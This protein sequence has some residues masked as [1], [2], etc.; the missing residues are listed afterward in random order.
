MLKLSAM[1]VE[2]GH[3]KPPV[4]ISAD[5]LAQ[6]NFYSRV[7]TSR[8]APVAVSIELTEG[9]DAAL[10]PSIYVSRPER[11]S[12]SVFYIDTA[13]MRGFHFLTHQDNGEV[14]ERLTPITELRK[15]APPTIQKYSV[16]QKV[17]NHSSNLSHLVEYGIEI[18]S[19][20]EQAIVAVT[21]HK[22]PDP[23]QEAV[24]LALLQRKFSEEE[25]AYT[26]LGRLVRNGESWFLG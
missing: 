12:S 4:E 2:L 20:N 18:P 8:P 1:I 7:L 24:E 3:F 11:G 23:M 15:L 21:L 19:S 22:N 26:G 17:P 5:G 13:S 16:T 9:L 6:Y 25:F 10:T 14:D